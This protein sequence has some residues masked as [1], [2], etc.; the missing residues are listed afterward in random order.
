MLDKDV[1]SIEFDPQSLELAL[2]D[3]KITQSQLN[4]LLGF[5]HRN[6]VNKIIRRKRAAT[7]T[8]LLRFAFV[9]KK[10]PK[11]FAKIS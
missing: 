1:S 8:D 7:A 4:Q 9:L 5:P 10:D 6:T 3:A 2:E 11:D